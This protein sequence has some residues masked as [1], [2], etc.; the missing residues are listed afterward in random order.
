MRKLKTLILAMLIAAMMAA[1][2]MA[3]TIFCD[4]QGHWAKETVQWGANQGVAKGYPDGTFR[5]DKT[6]TEAQFLA[7]LERTFTDTEDGEPWY[8][9][10]YDLAEK[11]NYPVADDSDAVILRTQVAEIVAG[12]QGVNYTGDNAIQYL[13]GKGLA[14]GTDPSKIT[15]QSYA[16]SKT[17]T[18]AEA[19]QFIK[20]LKDAG[21]EEIK[22]RP[23][24]P[25]PVEDLP[26]L[27]GQTNQSTTE[28]VKFVESDGTVWDTTLHTNCVLPLDMGDTTVLSIEKV[29]YYGEDF[30]KL[31]QT[32]TEYITLRKESMQGKCANPIEWGSGTVDGTSFKNEDGSYSCYYG[33]TKYLDPTKADKWVLLYDYTEAFEIDNPMN[34]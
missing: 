30:V 33:I 17:L 5:P 4:M 15:I 8:K 34:Q 12:T 27:P 26:E 21:V 2:V 25:S 10:Y 22:E 29:K 18:R 1:P 24:K 3:S 23:T 32:G 11:N 6:V 28:V 7:M 9:P 14:K 19:V 31:T 13:L 20:N 16:G